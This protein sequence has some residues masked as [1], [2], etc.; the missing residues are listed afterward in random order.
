MTARTIPIVVILSLTAL[1][2]PIHHIAA[3]TSQSVA[4]PQSTAAP[5]SVATPQSSVSLQKMV[6]QAESGA[7]VVV[8]S[9]VYQGPLL[10]SKPLTLLPEAGGEVTIVGNG[11]DAALSIEADRVTVVGLR[12][13]DRTVKEAPSVLVRGDEV[14]LEELY[15]ITGSDG[16]KIEEA[17]HVHV[18]ACVVEWGAG[19]TTKFSD[20]GN[21][22]DLFKATDARIR[23]NV[24]R[25]VYDGIYL[26][27]SNDTLV[28]HNH[29]EESRYGIHLMFTKRSIVQDNTGSLN[30]TG[31]M[32]MTASGTK[33]R[34]NTFTKQNE[35][36]NSQGI[37]L[38][39][40]QDAVVESN[41]VEGNR[42]GFHVEHSFNNRIEGNRIQQ[43][44][45]GIQLLDS[46]NNT[47]T[48]NTLTGNV[49]DALARGNA[50]NDLYANYWDSFAGIDVDGDGLSDTS[51]TIHPL[52]QGIIQKRPPFQL[53]FRTP[54]IV[55]LES[56]YEGNQSSWT[57]DRSPLMAP[58]EAWQQDGGGMS[59]TMALVGAIFVMASLAIISLLRRRLT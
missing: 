53:F 8:P 29:I 51:Y 6:N 31:A 48:G 2:F 49:T 1:L 59:G 19:E 3:A 5:Q 55:F 46:E 4:T 30:I 11:E 40:V 34:N 28:E 47:I 41:A 36:V 45:I 21:G 39:D 13:D 27:F 52:F 22:I 20:R 57:T 33:V 24:I 32:I 14:R 7:Q 23:G 16:I 50:E 58:P 9:G 54:G 25:Q 10:I 15:I 17:A 43:N 12:I 37:L 35:N 38:F 18:L 42:V 44:F 26:E 56:L